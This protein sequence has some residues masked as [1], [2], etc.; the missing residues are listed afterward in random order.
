MEIVGGWWRSLQA[1]GPW[2]LV[3]ALLPGATLFALL[4]WLSLRFARDGFGQIRQYAF[5]PVAATLSPNASV[6]RDWWSCKCTDACACLSEI[7]HGLGRCC[8]KLLRGPFSAG[9][10]LSARRA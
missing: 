10:L 6:Q 7:A 8:M 2:L 5:A 1:V 3:E 4:S 9:P